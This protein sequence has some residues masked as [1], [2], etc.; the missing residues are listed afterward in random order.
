[1]K[2]NRK[3]L[4]AGAVL[5]VIVL[6]VLIKSVR[7]EARIEVEVVAA[8]EQEINPTILASGTVNYLTEV[9]LTSE[10]V[11]KVEE[12]L[13]KEGDHVEAGQLLLRLD[14]ET[15]RNA[16]E[17]EEASRRQSLI[18]IERQRLALDLAEKKLKRGAQL[19]EQR[20]IGQEQYDELRNARDLAK[21]ELQSSE[22]ALR[23]AEAVLGE[24]REQLAKTDIRAPIAGTIVS[25]PIKV[26]E[27]AI[28]STNALAGSVLMT[29]ADTSAIEARMKVDEADIARIRLGQKADVYAAAF[30]D[31]GVPGVVQQI[32]LA[33][34]VEAQGRAYEVKL[35]LD[36]PEDLALRSGMSARAD[37]H[38][39]DGGNSLA[40]PVEAIVVEE[41]EDKQVRRHVWVV[42]DG[43][44][45]KRQIETGLSDDRWEAV[46]SG[47][48]AGEQVI[49]GP[50][51]ALRTLRE[52]DAVTVREKKAE[53]K[54]GGAAEAAAE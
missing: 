54:A 52:G 20:M 35:L 30:Q 6:P 26:G 17:R 44:A 25:L 50:A 5:A 41:G 51:K 21:V 37:I 43:R 11:A 12:I 45:G 19:L 18:S 10:V 46:T 39:G 23:R 40:V 1:M 31:T 22:E 34:T 49:T 42:R 9:N 4:A 36:V 38:L 14:P 2:L 16:V 7:G 28:P 27:T 32:A 33:P 29:I 53:D 48:Q 15:F 47:L 8:A 3:W 24:A 13:V